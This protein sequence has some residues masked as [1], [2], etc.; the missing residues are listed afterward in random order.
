MRVVLWTLPLSRYLPRPIF[1]AKATP[2]GRNLSEVD[3]SDPDG[4]VGNDNQRL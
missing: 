3:M 4:G 2:I 1:K